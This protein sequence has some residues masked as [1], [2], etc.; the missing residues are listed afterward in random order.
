[1][2]HPSPPARRIGFLFLPFWP[3]ER[4]HT[5]ASPPRDEPSPPSVTWRQHGSHR[6]ISAACPR[7]R[8]DG[9]Q[10]GMTLAQA[11]A[12]LPGLRVRRATPDEDDAALS[13][14]SDWCRRF[15]PLSRAEPPDGIWLDLSGCAHLFGGE[16][17]LLQEMAALLRRRGLSARI[18]IADT[19]GGAFAVARHAEGNASA[20]FSVPPGRLADAL[21]TLPV[22]ALRLQPEEETLLHRFGLRRI[23]ALDAIPRGPLSR[24]VG[25]GVLLRLDQAF[26]RVAEPICPD[27]P[28][29]LLQE[30][31]HGLEPLQTAESLV[32]AHALLSRRLCAR[33]ESLCLGVRQ[34]EL[35]WVR[36]DGSSASQF[37]TLAIPAH[38]A[39]HIGRLLDE[40]LDH[41]DP[42][43][44]VETLWLLAR[45]AEPAPRPQ[46]TLRS[47]APGGA[48]DA[49]LADLAPLIDTLA[50]RL[51]RH[52]LW[53]PVPVE[54][55]VPERGVGRR[56]PLEIPGTE[57]DGWPRALPRPIRLMDPPQPVRAMA[58]LPD[59]PPLW[60]IWRAHRHVVRRADGPERIAGEWWRRGSE[61]LALRDYFRVEDEH[62]RRFWLFRRGDGTDRNTG[63]LGWFLHGLF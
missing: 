24:R 43:E 23:G 28:P 29:P 6:L 30:R 17:A 13:A 15:T 31:L 7:A 2:S 60:F 3:I 59:H 8:A 45:I 58:A 54:S 1:M 18:A 48:D 44:G 51:G 35:V 32:S 39:R 36:V 11:Q 16:N 21:A 62:G 38:D 57:P 34:L 63:D 19:A 40:R 27:Q 55:D 37:V 50:L 52:R 4:R 5:H 25:A 14:L 41:M 53:R 46:T 9:V 22:L 56:A 47:L 26:G 49:S 42:G 33:L 10:P 61:W 20:T 12:M